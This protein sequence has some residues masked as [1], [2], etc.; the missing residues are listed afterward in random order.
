M[1]F[2][3]QENLESILCGYFNK[4]FQALL[5]K[6]KLKVLHY[7][8][9]HRK[10]DIFNKL[11]KNLQ[12]H[13]LSQLMIELMHLKITSQPQGA[14][15][16]RNRASSDYDNK[17]DAEDGAKAKEKEEI[18]SPKEK[19]MAEVLNQKRQEVVLSLIDNLNS[20]GNTDLEACLNAHLILTELT[21]TDY[22][23]AKLLEKENFVRLM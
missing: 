13:S 18:L 12:H 5:T 15:G 10:G 21:E 23:F 4:I 14:Q 7:L 3:D 9:I 19:Q 17:T 6:S 22:T 2:F 16:G 8:L 1:A 11:V 20:K